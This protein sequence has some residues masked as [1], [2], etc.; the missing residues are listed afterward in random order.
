[1]YI[2]HLSSFEC[3]IILTACIHKYWRIYLRMYIGSI[4][5]E[6]TPCYDMKSIILLQAK[7]S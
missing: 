6:S 1:M 2:D 4:L 5:V 7:D 3:C